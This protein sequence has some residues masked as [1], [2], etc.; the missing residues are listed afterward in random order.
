M[1][2]FLV[3]VA[4][5]Q[6]QEGARGAGGGSQQLLSTLFVLGS[7]ILIFYFLLIRPQQKRQRESAKMIAAL[8]R[9]DR[10]LTSGGFFGTV[11]DVKDDIVVLKLAEEVKV[12]V[13]KSAVQ[14]VV[15]K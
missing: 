10:V 6:Q 3:G 2:R 7:F 5:A 13:A 14:A 1:E 8:K 12:E 4:Q 11:W 15:S 9:G